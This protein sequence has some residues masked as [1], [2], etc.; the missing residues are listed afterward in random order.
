MGSA[1]AQGPSNLDHLAWCK[2][3]IDTFNRASLSEKSDFDMVISFGK[4]I[5][6]QYSPQG[7]STSSYCP[8]QI[9]KTLKRR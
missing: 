3:R 1:E 6:P 2:K 5:R 8:Y 4:R 7:V 9:S